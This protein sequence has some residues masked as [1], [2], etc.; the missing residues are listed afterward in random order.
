MHDRI[1]C[2]ERHN[3][4]SCRWCFCG[5]LLDARRKELGKISVELASLYFNLISIVLFSMSMSIQ[6]IES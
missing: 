3:H 4:V 5:S 2:C 1:S 6:S